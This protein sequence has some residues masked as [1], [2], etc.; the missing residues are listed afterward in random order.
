MVAPSRTTRSMRRKKRCGG[1]V[2][3]YAYTSNLLP[4]TSSKE[5]AS[6]MAKRIIGCSIVTRSKLRHDKPDQ[7][8]AAIQA[9]AKNAT[10]GDLAKEKAF[11]C[12]MTPELFYLCFF[13]FYLCFFFQS[14][15]A[16]GY[17]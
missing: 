8:H 6:S 13:F 11:Y 9:R 17:L 7:V 1:D 2:V 10:V 12:K 3:S 16:E 4:S 15:S 5:D 14:S